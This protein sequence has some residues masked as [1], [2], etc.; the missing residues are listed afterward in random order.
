MKFDIEKAYYLYLLIR[1]SEEKIIELYDSDKIKS[2]VHL[3]IGQEAIAVGV[4]LALNED[5]IVFSNYRG[6]AHYIAREANLDKMW[7]ELYGKQRGSARGKG[8][9]MHLNDWTKNF[10]TTSAIVSTAV[11][12]AVG[13]AYAIK[14]KKQNNIVICYHGDGATEEGVFWESLNFS[15]LHKLPIIFICENNEYAIY[16]HQNKRALNDP[17]VKRASAFG[18]NSKKIKS[19]ET[20][21]YFKEVSECIKNIKSGAGP[22]LLECMTTRWK[23]HVGVGDAFDLNYRDKNDIFSA[24]ENDDLKN[25]E[26]LLSTEK[27]E[28]INQ[29]IEEKLNKAVDFAENCKFPEANELY[30][31]VYG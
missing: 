11:P 5:D 18:V 30:E 25:L 7:A 24:I 1:R 12:E 22:Y 13:F 21:T 15:S 6:H 27:I 28:R 14:Y 8:G 23:D 4:S 17:I 2:P 3:S 9:S 16:T 29:K 26:K 20:E 31:Y 10:M 19:S